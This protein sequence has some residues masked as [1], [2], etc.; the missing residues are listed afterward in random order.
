MNDTFHTCESWAEE[1]TKS[2]CLQKILVF[3]E[4]PGNPGDSRILGYPRIIPSCIPAVSITSSDYLVRYA[5][6]TKVPY[7]YAMCVLKYLAPVA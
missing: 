2:R 3:F 6:H 4:I 7:R 5:Y 1:S